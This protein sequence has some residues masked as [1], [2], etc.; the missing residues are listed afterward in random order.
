MSDSHQRYY[1]VKETLEQLLPE[2]W[3][4]CESRM[5]NL[6]LLI[7]AVAGAKELTLPELA[8][9]M[10]LRAQDSSLV[11]RQR[12]WL[13]NE[14]VREREIYEPIIK[15]YLQAVSQATVPLLIDTTDMGLNCHTLTVA[16]GYQRRG[17]PIT[18]EC[19]PGS[20]GHTSGDRQVALLTYVR[21]L[22]V[23]EADVIVLGDGEFG[24]VQLIEWLKEPAW[25]YCLRA[26]KDTYIWY[27]EQWHRLDSFDVG[28]GEVIWLE[29]VYLTKDQPTGP[30]NVLLTWDDRQ[31]RLVVLVTNLTTPDEALYWYEKRYWIEP[32]F[33]DIKGHGFDLQTSRL[34]HPQRLSRLMLAIAL[35]YLWLCFLGIRALLTGQAKFVDRSDRR[36][37]S[38]F[39]IGRFWLKRRLKLDLP[40]PVSFWPFP[41]LDTLPSSGRSLILRTS[42]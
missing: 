21:T 33:G 6:S 20:R 17:L 2:Q 10:P 7:S 1:G 14:Q 13:L 34:R 15:P 27:E 26:A 29:D 37:R 28:S 3:R 11:Q 38:I 9:E 24:H 36:D 8:S 30:V 23:E 16:L 41:F 19:G 12:R 35:A 42:V 40:F 25:D 4:A 5:I 22:L 32:L 39:S 31:R 18:W